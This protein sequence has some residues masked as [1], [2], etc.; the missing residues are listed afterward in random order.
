MDGLSEDSPLLPVVLTGDLL[1]RLSEHWSSSSVAAFAFSAYF[2]FV[3]K[4]VD[5]WLVLAFVGWN[6]ASAITSII[7]SLD[8]T[9]FGLLA[10]VVFPTSVLGYQFLG[11]IL[12]VQTVKWNG[13][14]RPFLIPSRTTHTRLFP[15][16]HSFSYS[17]LVVGVPVGYSGN[18]NGMISANVSGPSSWLSYF[19][20]RRAWFDVNPADYLQRG[21][22]DDGLRGKL[23]DYLENQNVDPSQYPHAYLVTAARFLGY[24]FNPVSFWFLYSQEKV[25]SAIVLE[26]N[27]TFGERRPYLV[28][29]DFEAERHIQNGSTDDER[30]EPLRSRVKGSW[31]KD[32]HVSPFNSRKGSYSLLASDPLGPDMEGFRG[33]DITINLSSSKGHPKLVAR[34]F[35]EGDAL[36]PSSMG[37][38]QKTRFLL[39]WF[40]VGVAF[41]FGIAQ[42][43]SKRVWDAW[44]TISKKQLEDAFRQYLSHLVQQ[45]TAPIT[46]KYIPSGV[47]G[48]VEEV[49]SSS[50]VTDSSATAES[51][52]IKVLT[53]VFYSRFVHYAHDFE[54]VFSELAESCTLWVDKPELLPK[55][56]LKKA[57]PPLHASTPFDFLCFQLIKSLRSR[58]GRIERP[59]TSADQVSSSSQGLDIRDFR[60]SSMDAF[61]IGQGDTTLKKSY[62]A[63]VL[64]LFFADR[65]AFGNTDLLGMMELGARVGASWVLASLINQAIRGFS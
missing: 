12:D 9:Q 47:V 27:N 19:L 65:I 29:R 24:H 61:V 36:E 62:R 41:T 63:A 8:L 59:L 51:A 53:P 38:F 56:F 64:R 10:G 50:S 21:H 23:D 30:Q 15:K 3:G 42:N 44:P 35:S 1:D 31:N 58:P 57:S 54:A 45:S 22:R 28:T 4:A 5:L 46:V 55:I 13:P 34:L 40:W 17:Y 25:L 2:T 11:R 20:D 6:H 14:G 37:I 32:F 7:K 39:G 48:A 49:F 52:E 18:A 60:M 26:V 43:R 33:I 16:K